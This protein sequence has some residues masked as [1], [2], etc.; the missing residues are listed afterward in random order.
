MMRKL[1]VIA[2]LFVPCFSQAATIRYLQS[3]N[4][5]HSDE[6][7]NISSATV[8]NF[9]ATTFT[10]TGVLVASTT[11][12]TAS[13]SNLIIGNATSTG[14]FVF[15]GS[16]LSYLDAV[17]TGTRFDRSTTTLQ[18]ALFKGS[19]TDQSTTTFSG[20]YS[21]TNYGVISG[22]QTISG[23]KTD[24][25][26]GTYTAR[27]TFVSTISIANLNVFNVPVAISTVNDDNS[28]NSAVYIGR[29]VGDE[30]STTNAHGYSDSSHINRGGTIG[31]NSFDTRIIS[32]G[33]Y[34]YNHFAGFQYLP[35]FNSTGVI[36]LSYGLFAGG[37]NNAATITD[38]RGVN[39]ANWLSTGV[40][41]TLY[42]VYIDSMTRGGTNWGIV[43]VG[44][45]AANYFG[46][47]VY[48]NNGIRGTSTS[49]NATAGNYG[50][51]FST[52]STATGILYPATG[53]WG[54]LVSTTVA[55][56][57]YLFTGCI[58]QNAN[59]GTIQNHDFGISTTGGNSTV[60]LNL[61][62]SWFEVAGASIT[63]E[64][65]GCVPSLRISL[66]TATTVYLKYKSVYSAGQPKAKGRLSGV[67]IR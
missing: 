3:T 17:S 34:S 38:A 62:D 35:T 16:T 40:I 8:Q 39:V 58:E 22:S 13:I 53:D 11:I 12:S 63:Y 42:G 10:V 31:Y 18:G 44:T 52:T 46:G 6:V 56:G 45:T 50:Q 15:A 7:F 33:S 48:A 19:K 4:T 25:S 65:S 29:N 27:N 54:D 51:T 26:T 20:P 66:G 57:D 21:F 24:N 9:T 32:T 61:G 64:S 41:T 36:S 1:L 67:R 37:T 23:I 28:G 59:S 43:S 5:F 2:L 14:T 60:G 49:D 47:L 55:G 30:L